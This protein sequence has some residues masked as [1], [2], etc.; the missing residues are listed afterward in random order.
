M[1]TPEQMQKLTRAEL[2][3]EK[4]EIE[5]REEAFRH[6]Q[7]S[8]RSKPLD[9]WF[10]LIEEQ[11]KA[12]ALRGKWEAS[13]EIIGPHAGIYRDIAAE[14]LPRRGFTAEKETI[15]PKG[16]E[17]PQVFIATMSVSW[18]PSD[19]IQSNSKPAP[20]PH[21]TVNK[22]PIERTNR[23]KNEHRK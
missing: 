18:K 7:E 23:P 8:I 4:E 13:I 20:A 10:S 17:V 11:I 22:S 1:I 15:R 9:E 14:E 12:A 5:A 6:E 3:R 21:M 16:H 2:Q 19:P